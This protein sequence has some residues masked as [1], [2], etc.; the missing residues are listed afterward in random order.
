MQLSLEQIT[1]YREKTFRTAPRT[2]IKSPEAAVA[3]VNERGYI[4][5]WPV[6]NM[7]M[8]SLWTAVAGDRPV[9]NEHDDPG[10]ITWSWK[11][12]LLGKGR[13]YYGRVLRKRN[14]FISLDVLP[15]F[16]ALSPNYGDPSED[17]LIDYEQGRLTAA[18]KQIYEVLLNKGP[19]D[20]I[21][22]RKS[23]GLTS[24]SSDSE[25]MHALDVLQ[26]SFR[27]MPVGVSEAGAWHYAFI[28]D[29]VSRHFPDLI[30]RAHP[31][32]EAEARQKLVEIYLASVGAVP[33]KEIQRMFCN[34]PMNWPVEVL[35]RDLRKMEERGT[36]NQGVLVDGFKSPL[37]ASSLLISTVSS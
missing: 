5:F 25:Y 10:H 24:R 26:T 1:L 22:L 30:E 9:P 37:V 7:L 28:Y 27:I 21:A 17:Y 29:I 33:F 2:Q 11:D 16:Y 4:F 15:Y 34:Q 19:Q 32:S 18:A 8:P 14:T 36:V 35:E 3:Y 23:A 12:S 13:W 31:I 20:T 6:K